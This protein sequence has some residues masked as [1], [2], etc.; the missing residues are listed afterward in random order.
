MKEFA[1]K[2]PLFCI[3]VSSVLTAFIC[4]F[5]SSR[6]MLTLCCALVFASL[7]V[8]PLKFELK[9]TVMLM[10]AFSAIMSL[11]FFV[12]YRFAYDKACSLNGKTVA[13]ECTAISESRKTASGFYSVDIR[14][15][16]TTDDNED[17]CTGVKIHL[18]YDGEINFVPSAV[19]NANLT[20]NDAESNDKFDGDGIHISAFATEIETTSE[21]SEKSIVYLCYKAREFVE[22]RITCDDKDAAAFIKGMIL[23][24]K[25]DMSF[26]F[27]NK[28]SD[29]GMAHV[30]AV[31][32]MHLMFAVLFFDFFLSLLGADHRLRCAFAFVSVALFTVLS[33][34]SVSCIRSG[35]MISIFY[36]GKLIDRFS[37]GLTS[38]SLAS[39]IILLFTPFNIRCASFV[40]SVSATFGIIVLT[41]MLN[42]SRFHSFKNY[43]VNKLFRALC[44]ML[45]VSLAA[46]IACLPSFV[47]IFRKVNFLSPISNI[48]LIVPIQ[49]MF[50]LGF[51]GIILSFIPILPNII[52]NMISALYG[53]VEAVTDFE[54]GLK[55]T[56]I[57]SGYICFYLVFALF[58]VLIIGIYIYY[59]KF[60]EKKV[61]PYLLSYAGLCSVL[62]IINF[63]AN[64]GTLKASFVD[65]G[66]GSC[67]V[68]SR[69]ESA[70][71]VDCGGSYSDKLYETLK[72]SSVKRIDVLAITH[73]DTDH[74]KYLDYLI[75]SYEIDKIIYPEFC[76]KTK[77]L[78]SLERAAEN[79]TEICELS[80]DCS[81]DV[82]DSATLSVFVEC[83]YDS[84]ID[85]ST[86]ALYKLSYN[87]SSV[88]CTGDMDVH[89]EYVYLDYGQ[90]LDCDILLA[91]NHGS[92]SSSLAWILDLYT[93]EYAVISVGKDNDYGYPGSSALKRLGAVSKI[94][95]TDEMSTITFKLN[96]KGYTPVGK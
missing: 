47:L 78:S 36:A 3:C 87:G 22:S 20:V 64:H 75:N 6:D 65:V 77:I 80:S 67:T 34:F 71:I 35:I 79:G 95:R 30:M 50:Y 94:L 24:D 5:L 84:K 39:F 92:N 86:S 90:Q 10:L 48:I 33:G 41:P 46:C 1:K 4:S 89:Q 43:Y 83:A 61:Y 38:L 15:V 17:I 37:D 9:K 12:Y 44:M 70:V 81:F 21:R 27:R 19:F 57:N 2:R 16:G 59:V 88:I 76:E 31:S 26:I 82:I 73:A 69:N 68:F 55:Y 49:L 93:P 51:A 8:I 63:A 7:F 54:Y 25:S 18:Y 52:G 28:F 13:A 74:I 45:A 85:G 32:G 60:P 58:A 40:L 66:Q 91:A 96:K 42:I 11:A 14:L 72:Y 56:S 62:F 53:I 23:G 29:I